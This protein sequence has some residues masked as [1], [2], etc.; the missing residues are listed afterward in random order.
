GRREAEEREHQDDHA[1]CLHARSVATTGRR[2][3]PRAVAGAPG[4]VRGPDLRGVRQR[5]E[6]AGSGAIAESHAARHRSCGRTT[7][8]TSRMPAPAPPAAPAAAPDDRAL[9]RGI[10]VHDIRRDLRRH[11]RPMLAWYLLFTAFATVASAPL[12]TWSLA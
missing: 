5:R 2:L 12:T 9:L 11:L 3:V 4:R 6:P 1:D 10:L 7:C 8:N